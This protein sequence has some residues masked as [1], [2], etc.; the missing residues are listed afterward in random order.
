ML[1]DVQFAKREIYKALDKLPPE[2]IFKVAEVVKDFQEHHPKKFIS[3]EGIWKDIPFDVDNRT[4]RALRRRVSQRIL[5]RK[6]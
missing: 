3:L 2:A 1:S 5:K 6:I 4:I